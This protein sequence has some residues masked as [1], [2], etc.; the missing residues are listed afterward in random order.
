[1]KIS[2]PGII[3]QCIN[4]NRLDMTGWK[5]EYKTA[6]ELKKFW[7]PIWPFPEGVLREHSDFDGFPLAWYE[8]CGRMPFEDAADIK[9]NFES[10]SLGQNSRT[11]SSFADVSAL[12]PVQI[13]GFDDLLDVHTSARAGF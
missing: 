10:R 12:V 13:G 5:A 11:Q 6:A 7:E 9:I 1:M 2:I 3:A 8:P 4:S